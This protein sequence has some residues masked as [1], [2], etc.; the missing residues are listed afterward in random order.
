[1]IVDSGRFCGFQFIPFQTLVSQLLILTDFSRFHR[2]RFSGRLCTD[3]QFSWYSI[4]WWD[5]DELL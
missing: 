1:M 4:C 2:F 3:A 5:T